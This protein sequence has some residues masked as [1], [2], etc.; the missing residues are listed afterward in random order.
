MNVIRVIRRGLVAAM[1]AACLLL[2]GLLHAADGELK[3]YVA[4]GG[5]DAWSGRLAAP[6]A[7]RQDGPLAT[8]QGARDAL[9]C[10][11]AKGPLR[12][13][14]RVTI[15]EG[16][17]PLGE[18]IDFTP[19]DSGTAQCPILYTGQP[20]RRAVLSGG[21]AITGWKRQG[22]RFCVEIP[23]VRSGKW[24]FSELWIDGQRRTRARSPNQGYFY[25]TGQAPPLPG[26]KGGK[27]ISLAVETAYTQEQYDI[28]LL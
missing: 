13:P 17:Y 11:K 20:G 3:L 18:P 12:Q 1:A 4:P 9:R 21:R 10:L 16:V 14:V 8:L 28:V 2:A 19:E 7:P 25:T 27:P 24:Y 22:D 5:N 6:D 23:E 26:V 15:A